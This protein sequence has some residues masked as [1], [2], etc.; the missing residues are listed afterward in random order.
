MYTFS[1]FDKLSLFICSNIT[2]TFSETQFK[3]KSIDKMSDEVSIMEDTNE[4]K[5]QIGPEQ[6]RKMHQTLR[7]F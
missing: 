5:K 1:L 3:K 6:L 7:N 2:K 4:D